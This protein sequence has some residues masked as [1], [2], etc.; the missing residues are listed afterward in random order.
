MTER[1]TTFCIV[2]LSFAAACAQNKSGDILGTWLTE[3][4][5]GRVKIFQKDSKYFGK[6][7]WLQNLYDDQGKEI[8]DTKNPDPK[9]RN[10][11][12]L[13]LEILQN[14]VFDGN[15]IWEHGTIYDPNNGK[16]YHCILRLINHNTLKVRGYIGF[17]FI[18]QTQ[19]WKRVE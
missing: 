2:Y 17:S 12:I 19:V 14:F 11:K 8:T 3:S 15:N 13:A 9:L 18:G 16:T 7:I 5:Q 10:K 4:K 6:I 1:I